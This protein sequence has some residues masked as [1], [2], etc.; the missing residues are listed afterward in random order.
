MLETGLGEDMFVG[1]EH[2]DRNLTVEEWN[3][4][5]SWRRQELPKAV[6]K[7]IS[8]NWTYIDTRQS[9]YELQKER[10]RVKTRIEGNAWNSLLRWIRSV[11]VIVN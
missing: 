7:K 10:Q 1:S 9:N 5:R 6:A 8:A 4:S 3:S 2:S 11:A